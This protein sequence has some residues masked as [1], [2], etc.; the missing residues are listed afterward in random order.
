MSRKHTAVPFRWV[1]PL[2]QLVLCLVIL[3]PAR[4]YII[5]E[6]EGPKFIDTVRRVPR[7]SS[8]TH[9]GKSKTNKNDST[10]EHE[11]KPSFVFPPNPKI[12]HEFLDSETRMAMTA[13][14]NFPVLWVQVP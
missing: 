12:E 9:A 11:E 14:L 3:W 4:Y 2:S 10:G 6:M 1:L 5:A 8:S 13:G 7:S